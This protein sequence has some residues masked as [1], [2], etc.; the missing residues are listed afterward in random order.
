VFCSELGPRIAEV[1][2]E[3]IRPVSAADFRDS[4]KKIRP[5]VTQATIRSYDKWNAEHGLPL[6]R[7]FDVLS[8]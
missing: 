8:K 7:C 6:G 3:Q 1:A 2:A 5:S 4:L